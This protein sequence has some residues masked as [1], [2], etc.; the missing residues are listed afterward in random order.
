MLG[1]GLWTSQT[2]YTRVLKKNGLHRDVMTLNRRRSVFNYVSLCFTS[3]Q[4]VTGTCKHLWA[5]WVFDIFPLHHAHLRSD[6]LWPKSETAS[7]VQTRLRWV[8]TESE[9]QATDTQTTAPNRLL[10]SHKSHVKIVMNSSDRL[11][12]NMKSFSL[13]LFF[14]TYFNKQ[15]NS[16]SASEEE[17]EHI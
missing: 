12:E 16:K 11:K 2:C 4:V 13:D 15:K 3:D 10:Q 6:Y 9:T 14:F 8:V 1:T 7:V 5:Q 17:Y